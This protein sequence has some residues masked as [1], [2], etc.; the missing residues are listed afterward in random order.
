M[1]SE[2][3]T[4]LYTTPIADPIAT[5]KLTAKLLQLTTKRTQYLIKIIFSG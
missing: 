1:E 3:A 5:E 2:S 4:P